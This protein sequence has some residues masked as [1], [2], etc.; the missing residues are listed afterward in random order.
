MPGLGSARE[1]AASV[2][3]GGDT[4]AAT[5]DVSLTG[6]NRL[7]NTLNA[8]LHVRHEDARS[9]ADAVD[10]Q[11]RGGEDPGPLAGVPVAVKDNLCMRGGP[12]TCASRILAGHRPLYDATAVARLRAAGAVPVGSTNLDEFGMGSS[13]ENSAFGAT[14]N[15]WRIDRVPGGSSGGS[16]AAVAAGVVPLALGTDT[17]GSVRQPGAF[18]GLFALKPTYGRVSRFG[19]VAYASG[20]DT[21]GAFAR[22]VAGLAI[23]YQVI[24]GHDARDSTS[25]P[26]D[27]QPVPAV[28]SLDRLRVGV[29]KGLID[30]EG[31]EP[32]VAQGVRRAAAALAEAGAVLR[33]VELPDPDQAIGSYYLL[34][35]AEAS[36]NLARYDGVRYGVRGRGSTLAETYRATRGEGFGREV[37]RRIM[38]GTYVLSAGYR[39]AYYLTAQ[40]C[41]ARLS[42]D[43]R[44]LHAEHDLVLL[45]TSPTT[46]FPLGERVDD[47]VA[48]YLADLF[49][50]YA[51]LTGA[52]AI[53]VP[54]GFDPAGLPVGAQLM[55]RP[56]E[57]HRLLAVA[58]VLE[59]AIPRERPWPQ[60]GGA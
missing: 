13:T 8:F 4:A 15:P 44:A 22:D 55:G 25:V 14:R 3:S 41:R 53:N 29:A 52:P 20:F 37:K 45:P 43:F 42:R 59:R 16:A 2:R 54:V 10:R 30:R 51:N 19:L 9:E 38:L 32:A 23:L 36:S 5:V 12:T 60:G 26:R 50:V 7:D 17:G 58:G 47:P 56:W 35:T 57:E 49:T 40:G 48:M 28:T 31:V 21:V 27:V 18:C 11:V 39:D 24:A 46:A 34:A 33:D 6:I 1:I